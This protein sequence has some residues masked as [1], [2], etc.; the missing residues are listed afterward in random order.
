MKIKN[1][2][3]VDF[4]EIGIDR[5]SITYVQPPDCNSDGENQYITF[6]TESIPNSDQGDYYFNII[7]EDGHWSFDDSEE[8]AQLAQDF[9]S[10]LFK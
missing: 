9:I 2:P 7:T 1:K 8:L 4:G 6:E 10:R 5:M 3:F